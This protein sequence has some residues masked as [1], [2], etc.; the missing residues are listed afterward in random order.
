MS[1]TEKKGG[2]ETEMK[3]ETNRK[4]GIERKKK[5]GRM[6]TE[7]EKGENNGGGVSGGDR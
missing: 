7:G 2:K 6:Y 1:E 4:R 5:K 3:R